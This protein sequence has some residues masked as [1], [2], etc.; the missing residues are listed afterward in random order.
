MLVK[1]INKLKFHVPGCQRQ[2][3]V[4]SSGTL[5]VMKSIPVTT[6]TGYINSSSFECS[7]ISLP[8]VST[9]ISF[10]TGNRVSIRLL[11]K[12]ITRYYD[13]L[14]ISF[15]QISGTDLII[16]NL[17]KEYAGDYTCK[18]ST[19][20]ET[21]SSSTFLSVLYAPKLR[22]LEYEGNNTTEI[23]IN[24]GLLYQ[25]FFN[26]MKFLQ[27]RLSNTKARL[28]SVVV[29]MQCRKPTS[30]GKFQQWLNLSNM[31]ILW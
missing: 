28:P 30:D 23:S 26:F 12:N 13:S 29:M 21:D 19:D 25:A 24:F 3:Q 6:F 18:I 22:G 16:S 31:K 4:K 7:F 2:T 9:H 11:T 8:Y 15:H 14:I 27:Q 5:I 1:K 10:S 17:A 20:D